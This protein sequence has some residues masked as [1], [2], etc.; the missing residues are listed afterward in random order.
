MTRTQFFILIS[1]FS[2]FAACILGISVGSVF[3]ALAITQQPQ[4]ALGIEPK[5]VNTQVVMPINTEPVLPT[6][7]PTAISVIPT[8]IVPPATFTPVPLSIETQSVQYPQ[9]PDCILDQRPQIGKITR[10]VDGD[11]VHVLIDG[12]D[13]AVR[14]IGVDT[15]ESTTEHEFLGPE[16][17]ALNSS[18]V[19]NQ[20]VVLYRDTSETD[21]FDR[22]LR[23]VFV[24]EKFV[25]AEL[26]RAGMAQA[27]D[28]EPDTACSELLTQAMLEAQQT[29]VGLWD[30]AAQTT[31]QVF[32]TASS[33]SLAPASAAE[34]PMQ[35]PGCVIKGNVNSEGRKIYHVPGMRDYEETK[36]KPEEG[37][38][39]FC[40]EEEARAAGFVRAQQ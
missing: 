12:R 11:T 4:V 17:S 39:W 19:A 28:Y 27:I 23:Y 40:S 6:L 5:A 38:T 1:V 2:A 22:L 37:D 26:V 16:S 21:R 14:Y 15:P 3:V 30:M 36:I 9:R 29:K 13:F 25:N 7:E 8:F 18:L 10:V 34:E 20:D 24:G 32:A 31:W 35:T 33:A